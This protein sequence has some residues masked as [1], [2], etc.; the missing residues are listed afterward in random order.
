VFDSDMPI[1]MV[2]W[3]ISR[4]YAVFNPEQAAALRAIGTP[5]AQFCV[6]IQATLVQFALTHT[7]L[8]GFDLPDPITMAIA[9]DPTVAT[10]TL[11]APVLIVTGDGPTRGMT[12][13]DHHNKLGCPHAAEVVLTA[14]RARF[15]A[16]LELAVRDRGANQ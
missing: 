16:L 6:D 12:M 4:I 8:A 1:T 15:D 11:N 13:I 9:I 7:R 5:L 3:D 10:Q 2:G 14:D